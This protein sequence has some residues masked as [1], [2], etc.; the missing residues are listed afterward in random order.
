MCISG[1]QLESTTRPSLLNTA[2]GGE[3]EARHGDFIVTIV[4]CGVPGVR[5]LDPR[6]PRIAAW[7]TSRRDHNHDAVI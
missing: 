6:R 1:T 7:L 4:V 2:T 3:C 5:A